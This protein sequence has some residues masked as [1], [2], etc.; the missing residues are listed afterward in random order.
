MGRA[1]GGGSRGSR[2]SGS[3][4]SSRSSGGHRSSSSRAGSSSFRSSYSRSSSSYSR[5][6]VNVNL[7][8]SSYRRSSYG[9]PSININMGGSGG[10][11]SY[12]TSRSY[13]TAPVSGVGAVILW[14]AIVAIVIMTIM[15]ITSTGDV[16]KSTYAREKIQ[17]NYAFDSDCVTDEIGWFDS[18]ASTGTRL[19]AFYDKTGVQP[20]VLF[21]AYDSSLTTDVA[22]EDWALQYYEDNI[23][24]ENSFL[25]VYFA[26]QDTD[27]DVGYM[28]YVNG[29]SVNGMMDEEAVNIFWDYI[30]KY[31][32]TDL[33][34][35][36]VII[37]A[38]TET[39][40]RITTKSKTGTDVLYVIVTI[41]GVAV[42]IGGILI[43]M[44]AK[45]RNESE[46]AAETERI[47]KAD[48]GDL[49]KSSAEEDLVNKYK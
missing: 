29:Y 34:T 28:T 1:G 18:T 49:T 43:I 10:I 15:S 36:D 45:R 27:N 20:V 17:G 46:K 8:G 33:S 4:S 40:D 3:R 11:S 42:V 37:N 47:L 9:R 30:D 19:K 5:P 44:K 26:E 23:E 14:V 6:S 25:Y 12:G 35:D 13:G 48:I 22:K 7:G 2:S 21:K 32:Y 41:V 16:T 24:D 39:A 38:F 31:W